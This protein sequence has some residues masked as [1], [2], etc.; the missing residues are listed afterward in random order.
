MNLDGRSEQYNTEVGVM[1]RSPTLARELLSLVDF[2]SSA[3]RV[4][5]GA[6]G[7][8]RWVNRRQGIE[9]VH[10]SEPEVDYWRRLSS[11]ILGLLIPHDWL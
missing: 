5:L 1:I 8:L 3:Y 7:K 11:R 6:D 2:E 9:T 4:D 10:D